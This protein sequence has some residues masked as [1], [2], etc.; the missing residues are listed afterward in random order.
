M[1][2]AMHSAIAAALLA[3][4]PPSYKWPSPP[5]LS[6]KWSSTT[7][8]LHVSFTFDALSKKLAD[9]TEL[10]ISS[11]KDARPFTTVAL[12]APSYATSTQ[13][14]LDELLPSTTYYL[15]ARCHSS[16]ISQTCTSQALGAG[17]WSRYGE[18]VACT[19]GAAAS[20]LL[21]S[22]STK[23]S[24]MVF[25]TYRISERTV[26]VDYMAAHDSGDLLGDAGLITG[27][28]QYEAMY[29][30]GSLSG[31]WLGIELEAVAIQRG[32]IEALPP[33]LPGNVTTGGDPGF[34]DYLSC[35]AVPCG[36]YPGCGCTAAIDRLWGN[37]DVSP[38]ICHDPTKGK[39]AKC[40]R[41][42]DARRVSWPV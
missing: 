29:G 27:I 19:T 4:L 8:S 39:G 23:S 42:T 28:A 1:P 35:N 15:S 18:K 11:S 32:C 16:N 25:E 24:A 14:G 33:D 10:G 5:S 38:P 9:L 22:S 13:I 20:S 21:A 2:S 37:L 41:E 31:S 40:T 3:G 7:H 34:A 26:E 12:V 30:P 17:S 6:C 36:P